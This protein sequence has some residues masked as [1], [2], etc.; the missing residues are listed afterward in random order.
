MGESKESWWNKKINFV[1][2][3]IK[4]CFKDNNK[5]ANWVGHSKLGS[6]DIDELFIRTPNFYEKEASVTGKTEEDTNT[7]KKL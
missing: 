4:K 2:I 5:P 3:R 6:L 1:C 7:A